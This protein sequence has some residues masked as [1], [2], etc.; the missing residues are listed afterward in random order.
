MLR[1]SHV[2]FACPAVSQ[3]RR[4]L[5]LAAYKAGLDA[6]ANM[7]IVQPTAV[8]VLPWGG[9]RYKNGVTKERASNG[10]NH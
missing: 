1:E 9:W 8:A 6:P 4:S 2:L 5:G 3:H 10:D 7:S